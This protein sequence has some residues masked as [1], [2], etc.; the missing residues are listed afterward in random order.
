[1]SAIS[2]GPGSKSWCET[3]CP[4]Q[5]A[6]DDDRDARIAAL[7]SQLQAEEDD[8]RRDVERLTKVNAALLRV[9][10]AAKRVAIINDPFAEGG[11]VAELELRNALAAL[12][13]VKT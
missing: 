2:Y 12:R 1:M 11:L 9:A 8:H 4:H 5:G 10:E 7:V 6:M 13:E 3:T